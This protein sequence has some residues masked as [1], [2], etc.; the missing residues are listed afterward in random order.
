MLLNYLTFFYP[1]IYTYD[2][3]EIQLS[4]MMRWYWATFAQH[5]APLTG[6]NGTP[7]SIM[8]QRYNLTK[9][10]T[11]MLNTGYLQMVYNFD[12]EACN[13]WDS[14]GYP[15]TNDTLP[16]LISKKNKILLKP[17]LKLY[18]F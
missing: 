7:L 15:W 14:F 12:T 6:N 4:A 10:A 1:L 9:E 11:I 5:S 17:L 13:M 18:I 16:T 3:S 2:S 8:W